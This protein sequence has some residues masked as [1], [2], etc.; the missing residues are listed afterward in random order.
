MEG[1]KRGTDVPLHV[2]HAAARQ[3][4]SHMCCGHILHPR[5]H[6]ASIALPDEPLEAAWRL[7]AAARLSPLPGAAPL[8]EVP[9]K[10]N[11]GLLLRL[12]TGLDGHNLFGTR[13]VPVKTEKSIGAKP[14]GLPCAGWDWEGRAH[15]PVGLCP[16]RPEVESERRATLGR[17]LQ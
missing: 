4:P 17:D 12:T 7:L 2:E 5:K 3:P 13:I 8:L 9:H 11:C 10:H 16:S 6:F 15:T 1:N 14:K